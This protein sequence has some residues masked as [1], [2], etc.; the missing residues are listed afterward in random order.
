[1][2]ADRETD[3]LTDA[4]VLS[5]LIARLGHARYSR[6]GVR[7]Y[8]GDCLEHMRQLPDAVVDLT[9]TSPP[10]NIGKE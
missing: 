8:A 10:Y 3:A 4:D 6:P 7:I 5:D 9:V 1:M 2:A